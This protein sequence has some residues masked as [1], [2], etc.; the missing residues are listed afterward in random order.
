MQF[1]E[2][3]TASRGLP[4]ISALITTALLIFFLQPTAEGSASIPAAMQASFKQYHVQY[5]V[6]ADGTYTETYQIA[7][8]VRTEQEVM[9]F[10][11]MPVGTPH[12]FLGIGKER[13]VEV[14]TAY[15]LKK[16]GDHIPAIWRD[17]KSDS[18]GPVNADLTKPAPRQLQLKSIAFQKVEVGDT[19]VFSYKVI[20]NE[21]DFPN[22]IAITQAF[23]QFIEYDDAVITVNAPASLHLRIKSVG[24]EKGESTS[25]GRTQHWVWKYQ[26][27]KPELFQPNQ[28]PDFKTM[29]LV[30][31]SSFKDKATEMEAEMAAMNR[32][33]A[34]GFP[35]TASMASYPMPDIVM[36]REVPKQYSRPASDWEENDKSIYQKLLLTQKFNVLVVPFQVQ[37]YALDRPTRSLMTAEL[38]MAVSEGLKVHMPDPYLVERALGEGDRRL[39]QDE[40]YDFANKLGVKRIIWGYVGHNRGHQMALTVLSQE[41]DANGLLNAQTKSSTTKTFDDIAFTDQRPPIEVYQS[42]LPDILKSIGINRPMQTMQNGSNN[43]S[44]TKLPLSPLALLNQKTDPARDAL[45]FQLLAYLTPSDERAQERFA[46]KSYLAAL[47]MAPD[48]QNY[49]ILKARAFMLLGWRPAALDVLGTPKN[50]EEAELFA[51]LNGNLPDVEKTSTQMKPGIEKIMAE[52]DANTLGNV[53][54]GVNKSRAIAEISDLGLPGKAWPYLFTRAFLDADSWTRFDNIY[55]KQLLDREFPIKDYTAMGIIRGAASLGD[56]E[57]IQ[58]LMDLSVVNHIRKLLD[59]DP[60]KWCC[61]ATIVH[62]S[63]MDYLNLIDAIGDDNLLRHAEFLTDNQGAPD[64]ALDY[65]NRIE[66]VYKGD[67]RFTLDQGMAEIMKVKSTDGAERKGLQKL[68]YDNLFNAFYWEQGQTF[69]SNQA[70]SYLSSTERNDYG[71]FDNFYASDYPFKPFYNQWEMDNQRQ[72]SNAKAALDNS[73]FNLAPLEYLNWSYGLSKNKDAQA[74][75]IKSI[76]GRFAGNPG[77]YQMLAKNSLDNGDIPS[78]ENDYRESIK[79]QPKAWQAYL[80]LGM[81]LIKQGDTSKADTLFM[82]YPGFKQDSKENPV[83]ISNDAWEAGS[84][85]FW[86]GDFSLAIPLYEIASRQETGSRADISS[87]VRLAL[88]SGDYPSA[89]SGSLALGQRYNDTYA[90]R[91]YLGMLHAMGDSKDAWEAFNVLVSQFDDPHI[92]ESALVGQHMAGKTEKQIAD[93]VGQQVAHNTSRNSNLAAHYLL[94]AGITDRTPSKNFES[95][96]AKVAQPVWKLNYGGG[97]VIQSSDDGRYQA[98]QGPHTTDNS[99]LPIGVFANSEKSRVKSSLIYFA[100]AYRAIRMGDDSLARTTLREASTLYDLSLNDLSYMLPYYAY[101]AAKSGSE[102]SIQTYM[103][104][105]SP[106][107]RGFDYLLAEAVISGMHGQTKES[108]EL[109]KSAK[110]QRPFTESRPL[111]TEYEYGE[112]C[113]WLYQ[114]TGR[115]EFK[116]IAIDWAEKNQKNQ[117][118]FAWAYAMEAELSSN[119]LERKRAIAMANY[120]D[121]ESERLGKIAKKE[122]AVAVREFAGMNPF[123]IKSHSSIKAPI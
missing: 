30:H 55:V 116:E 102:A 2:Q 56:T 59:I 90:Y 28:P 22:N 4:H 31:I 97:L 5:D 78:A 108:V 9:Q 113:E 7:K 64:A 123:M 79:A 17:R 104:N 47:G 46:E 86:M 21:P 73:M 76:A 13:K 38:T 110:L 1:R 92:W 98:I 41:R 96:L 121:P 57:K 109:L 81:L 105:I 12:S 93:W 72:E 45:Y 70:F 15:T 117:P 34:M 77:L 49:R 39:K 8:P 6:N 111:Q 23:P 106:D 16:N 37:G 82:E 119:P 75:L 89:M 52:L 88:L 69:Y 11:Q 67:P 85:F 100:E 33:P 54:A 27:L 20:K 14:L 103:T 91:D 83:G 32:R 112:I 84:R 53:Y 42:I 60:G 48:S 68:A 115:S 66:G 25:D 50:A 51:I 44:E 122:R 95:Y 94:M 80:D 63:R 61:N 62:P 35:S 26:N 43:I 36:S 87:R 71:F 120:L 58:T 19:L 3:R 118:W 74:A 65:L 99:I 107:K 10:R 24:I 29:P 114:A 18:S 40:V 101:A